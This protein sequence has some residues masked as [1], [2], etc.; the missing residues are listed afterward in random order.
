M[1]LRR[2]LANTTRTVR[3]GKLREGR[4]PYSTADPASLMVDLSRRIAHLEHQISR[5][6]SAHLQLASL[7]SLL[8]MGESFRALHRHLTRL[9]ESRKGDIIEDRRVRGLLARYKLSPAELERTLHLCKTRNEA[10]HPQGLPDLT[11]VDPE[12]TRIFGKVQR[13]LADL[14]PTKQQ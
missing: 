4:S 12:V 9:L 5:L 6:H 3:F 2:A 13:L 10:A 8:Q 11:E 1:W 7:Q 14:A